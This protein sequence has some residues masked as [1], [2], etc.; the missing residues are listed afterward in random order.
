M[1]PGLSPMFPKLYSS[2]FQPR[3]YCPDGQGFWS[4]HLPL[5]ADLVDAIRP[6]LLVE[7]GTYY[8]E[9]YFGFC[10]AIQELGLSCSAYAV[11]NWSGDLHT[12]NYGP[13]VLETVTAHNAEHYASFSSLVRKSFDEAAALFRDGSIDLLHL[14]GCHTYPAVKHDFETWLPK[15]SPGGVVLMHDIAVRQENFGVWRFWQEISPAFPSFAFEH[16]CGLGVLANRKDRHFQNGFLA[17]LLGGGSDPDAIRGHYEVCARA[18]CN[19]SRVGPG[20]GTRCQ[21]F[22]PDKSGYAEERSAS[23]SV[24]LSEWATMDVTV[25]GASGRLRLDPSDRPCVVEIAAIAVECVTTGETL[26]RLDSETVKNVSCAGT[27]IRIPHENRLM[28]LSYGEDPQ[29]LLPRIES[30]QAV[31]CLIDLRIDADLQGLGVNAGAD[32]K[33]RSSH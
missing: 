28:I 22:W 29:V 10:Q 2:R 5:A 1:E 7:L 12:G 4:G 14:D 19:T 20:R 25:P 31:R 30:G 8:G 27:A 9:S 18:L 13:S 6:S 16:S 11:D 3:L 15:V 24:P 21:I 17:A 32:V 23:R 33:A 26:W